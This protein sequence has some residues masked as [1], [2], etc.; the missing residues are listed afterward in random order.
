MAIAKRCGIGNVNVN[1]G[2]KA[3]CLVQCHHAAH[4]VLIACRAL[5]VKLNDERLTS[6]LNASELLFQSAFA[7][8]D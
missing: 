5:R 7:L 8:I 3:S 4:H 6:T 1:I 2:L